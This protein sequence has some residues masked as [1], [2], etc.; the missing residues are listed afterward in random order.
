MTGRLGGFDPPD[1]T[2]LE[3]DDLDG[4]IPTF[5]ATRRDLNVVEHTNIEAAMRWAFNRRRSGTV[6]SLLTIPFADSLHRRMFGDV[7]RWAGV[8][9][10]RQTN[11]GI[12]PY[13][14][15]TEMK[16]L[17]GDANY[18]HE[19]DT[20]IPSEL[21]VRIHHR[22]VSIHPY[23]NGNGRHSRLLA[24]LYLHRSGN[25]PLNWSAGE[26]FG[27]ESDSRRAYIDALQLA[28]RGDIAPLHRFATG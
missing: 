14:I 5:L 9:R 17:F 1:A 8:H 26:L 13:R 4:L 19:H 20:Y 23:R 7:S 15:V 10:S 3:E 12:E 11:I 24:D 28:D 27:A 21:A 22:L 18:W 16:L 2:P 6:A 25:R